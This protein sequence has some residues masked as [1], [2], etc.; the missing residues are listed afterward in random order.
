MFL[1]VFASVLLLIAAI[2]VANRHNSNLIQKRMDDFWE[3]ERAAN[4]VRRQS[5]DGLD[6]LS[7]PEPFF[8]LP[9]PEGDHRAEEA[10]RI[11]ENLRNEKIVNLGGMSNTDL[12][13]KYGPANLNTLTACDLNYTSLVR[14]LQMYAEALA[15]NDHEAEATTLLEYSLDSGSDVS[16]SYLLLAKLYLK[17]GDRS[18]AEALKERAEGLNSLMKPSILRSLDRLLNGEE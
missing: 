13:L 3:R 18:K 5:L 8:S 9:R 10:V 16:A 2:A 14:A 1:P 4:E 17:A 12:K 6:Y 7:I 11:L 15:E